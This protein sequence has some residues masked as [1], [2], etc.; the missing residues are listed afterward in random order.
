MVDGGDALAMG[1][2]SAGKSIGF[3]QTHATGPGVAY[4]LTDSLSK[5]EIYFG[6]GGPR[7]GRVGSREG[8]P[9]D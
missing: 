3:C 6:R 9:V 8:G 1:C 5:P 2:D 4:S 7:S